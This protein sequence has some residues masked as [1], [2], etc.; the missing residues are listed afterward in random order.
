M[1]ITQKQQEK[2]LKALTQQVKRVEPRTELQQVRKLDDKCV[3]TDTYFCVHLPSEFVEHHT[4]VDIRTKGQIEKG[5]EQFN[6]EGS[7]FYPDTDR[8]FSKLNDYK[9]SEYNVK[10]LLKKLKGLKN[11][12]ETKAQKGIVELS[13]DDMEFGIVNTRSLK[14]TVLDVQYLLTALK[15]MEGPFIYIKEKDMG[16]Y[17]IDK[18]KDK[19]IDIDL[20]G[21]W[22]NLMD[23]I[24][25]EYPQFYAW[26]DKEKD[27]WI[28]SNFEF[29]ETRLERINYLNLEYVHTFSDT[30]KG[31]KLNTAIRNQKDQEELTDW[32]QEIA[33]KSVPAFEKL[34]AIFY[35]VEKVMREKKL[36]TI[37]V[38]D[39]ELDGM[40]LSFELTNGVFTVD[41]TSLYDESCRCVASFT[42]ESVNEPLVPKISLLNFYAHFGSI[43]SFTD[44]YW[45]EEKDFFLDWLKELDEQ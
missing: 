35:E 1:T 39:Y 12:P 10:E 38:P 7:T 8:L 24:K 45:K 17:I 32:L 15:I 3:Y 41:F 5:V 25:K 16:K 30:T 34:Y 13:K 6:A 21:H 26:S 11:E 29:K 31:Y 22:E 33:T 44:R 9:S 40:L 2:V 4:T 27:N 42:R 19:R 43:V 23:Y 14:G 28:L 37:R 18:I 36:K 20:G